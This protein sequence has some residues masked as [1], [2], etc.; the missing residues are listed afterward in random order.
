M[1]QRGV[2]PPPEH[3]V[4]CALRLM[5]LQLRARML[6]ANFSALQEAA[7]SSWASSSDYINATCLQ[8]VT[9]V[10]NH[11]VAN[12]STLIVTYKSPACPVAGGA[13]TFSG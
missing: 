11:K 4:H 12:P 6:R 9:P 2:F 10:L 8:P 7:L 3:P 1:G 13:G 5:R